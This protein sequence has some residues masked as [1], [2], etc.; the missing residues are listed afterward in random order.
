MAAQFEVDAGILQGGRALEL[1][2]LLGYEHARTPS[3]QQSGCGNAASGRSDHHHAPSPDREVVI[4]HHRSF[5]V[6]RLKSAKITATI[7]NRVITFGSLHPSN[8][9]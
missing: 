7:R 4:H 5:N 6:V 3:M 8:S 1:R 2:A 9:K